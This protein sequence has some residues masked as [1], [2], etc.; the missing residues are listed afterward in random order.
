MTF[1]LLGLK[2]ILIKRKS[3][4]VEQKNKQRVFEMKEA[5]QQLMNDY[6]NRRLQEEEE[7]R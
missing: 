3:I 4:F 2:S 6:L 1:V 7:M 5:A